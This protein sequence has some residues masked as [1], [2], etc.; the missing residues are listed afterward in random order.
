[1]LNK[2]TLIEQIAKLV[3]NKKLNISALARGTTT[4]AKKMIIAIGYEPLFHK[5]ITPPTIVD[6]VSSPRLVVYIIG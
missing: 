2:T 3:H 4:L 5:I 6:G 1:M